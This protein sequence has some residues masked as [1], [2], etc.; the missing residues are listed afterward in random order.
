MEPYRI[1]LFIHLLGMLGLFVGY[2][3]EWTGTA[4]LLGSK[5]GEQARSG[6]RIYRASLP[7]SGPSLVVLIVSGGYMAGVTGA[8]KEGWIIA[9]ILGIMVAL[10]MGFGLVM[11]RMRAMRNTLPE[12]NAALVGPGLLKVQDG[13]VATLVRTR[14]FLAVGIVFVMTTKTALPGSL[15]VLF[16]AI[17]VGILTSAT[18]WSRS[19]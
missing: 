18:T 8:S 6:L 2:G 13:F 15:A 16:G 4:F 12:G 17:V 11:P 19:S 3:L 5:T 14:F 10:V 7:L 1:V 9:S